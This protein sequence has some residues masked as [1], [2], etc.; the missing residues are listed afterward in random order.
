MARDLHPVLSAGERRALVREGLD[1]FNA[2]RY[3]EAH[4]SWEEIWRSTRPEPKE[5]FRGLIQVAVGLYHHHSRG[6]PDPAGRVLA[7]GLRRIEAY[8]QGTEG[9]D[10]DTLRAGARRWEGWLADPHGAPPQPPRLSLLGDD[11]GPCQDP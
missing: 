8:P 3:Y 11:A 5:L 6:N 7:R 4:E 1:H 10:L 2:G 9:L